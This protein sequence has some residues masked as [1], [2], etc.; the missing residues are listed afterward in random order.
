[1]G[2]KATPATNFAHYAPENQ[3]TDT[4]P[5]QFLQYRTGWERMWDGEEYHCIWEISYINSPHV[6]FMTN[7][8]PYCIIKP[9][10][11]TWIILHTTHE[12]FFL[13]G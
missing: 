6:G 11:K 5:N 3:E 4:L 7:N 1:L 8:I 13:I 9:Q 2:L 12:T 10:K